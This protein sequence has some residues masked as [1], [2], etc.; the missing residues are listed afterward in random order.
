MQLVTAAQDSKRR[1]TCPGAARSLKGLLFVLKADVQYNLAQ[2]YVVEFVRTGHLQLIRGHCLVRPRG[3]SLVHG[4]SSRCTQFRSP[5]AAGSRLS[6]SSSFSS[7]SSS[8]PGYPGGKAA[9]NTYDA[10]SIVEVILDTEHPE[11]FFFGAW[12]VSECRPVSHDGFS[13]S[14]VGTVSQ[15]LSSSR[16]LVHVN[17]EDV[18]F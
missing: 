2:V 16:G 1:I 15:A 5:R 14:S 9:G 17:Y 6:F 18:Y 4:T 3:Q 12:A 13:S 11:V 10:G 7:F 8:R